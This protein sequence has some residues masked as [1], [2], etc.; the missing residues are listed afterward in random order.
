VESRRGLTAALMVDLG[1]L[2]KLK[3]NFMRLRFTDLPMQ[4]LY[5]E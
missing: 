5:P 3:R 2:P 4:S 1:E